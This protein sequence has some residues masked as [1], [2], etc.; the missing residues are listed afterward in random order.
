MVLFVEKLFRK[1]CF[2]ERVYFHIH[3]M[4]H[5]TNFQKVFSTARFQVVLLD[6]E[7]NCRR[8]RNDFSM[9]NRVRYAL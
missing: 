9:I 8:I 5:G 2:V 7:R 6:F 3:F 4:L 1:R